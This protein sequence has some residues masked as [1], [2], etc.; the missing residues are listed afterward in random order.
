MDTVKSVTDM[1]DGKVLQ[2]GTYQTSRCSVMEAF[3]VECEPEEVDRNH[4]MTILFLQLTNELQKRPMSQCPT[5][6]SISINVGVLLHKS[7][8]G[9]Y[10]RIMYKLLFNP[11]H[12]PLLNPLHKTLD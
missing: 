12:K 2:R 10:V 3:M 8:S 11:L 7:I 9:L 1:C 6:F 5:H 4:P